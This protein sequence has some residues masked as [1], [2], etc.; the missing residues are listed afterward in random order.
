MFELSVGIS[1][2]FT[3]SMQMPCSTVVI[4][5]GYLDVFHNFLCEG[6]SRILCWN[7]FM[8]LC[9][10]SPSCFSHQT[11]MRASGYLYL[12]VLN[13]EFP[14]V[15]SPVIQATG[16]RIVHNWFWFH[17]MLTSAYCRK[18]SLR[19]LRNC[20]FKYS[21]RSFSFRSSRGFRRVSPVRGSPGTKI[22]AEGSSNGSD[23]R[24]NQSRA[25]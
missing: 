4:Y 19:K 16:R 10:F 9:W 2:Q 8:V 21:V 1:S 7:T 22:R 6:E 12:E 18:S 11:M 20:T 24:L 23:V 13:Y 15:M 14:L 25:S 3:S 5:G 17:L